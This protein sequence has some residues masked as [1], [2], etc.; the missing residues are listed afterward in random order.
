MVVAARGLPEAD[1]DDYPR[2]GI[3]HD[4]RDGVQR[5]HREQAGIDVGNGVAA[6]N[7]LAF[8]GSGDAHKT[9]GAFHNQ[10]HG[11]FVARGAILSV[12]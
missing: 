8:I 1:G 9:T 3:R 5:D 7:L 12:T 10:V 6:P 4:E 2:R 11:S